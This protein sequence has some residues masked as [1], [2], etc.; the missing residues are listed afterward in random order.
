MDELIFRVVKGLAS[1][2]EVE[3]LRAWRATSPENEEH[4]H[5]LVQVLAVTASAESPSRQRAL[6]RSVEIIGRAVLVP[7]TARSR[8]R[9]LAW[10]A[11]LSAAALMLIGFAGSRFLPARPLPVAFAADEFVTGPSDMA[12]LRLND[13]T[14]VRLAP[15]SRLRVTGGSG[16]REVSLDGHAYFAVA[17]ARG[18]PFVVRTPAGNAQ[19]LGTQFELNVSERT[20]RLV[21]V[22]GV[23]ALS[24]R[25]NTVAVGAGHMSRVVDGEARPVV[26]VADPAAAVRWTGKLLV[27]QERPLYQVVAEIQRQYGVRVQLADPSLANETVTAWFQ[28][29]SFEDVMKVICAVLNARCSITT[30]SAR[31]ERP[32]AK[33]AAA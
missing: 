11:P 17:K 10:V 8:W 20:L 15:R 13:G 19:V 29:R 28:D 12:T 23:V 33:H 21:V 1:G 14:I 6:P 9:R 3:A 30:G 7:P 16:G 31:L 2:K 27:F 25:R 26:S 5:Q 18:T 4:Y 24:A 22:E 32:E